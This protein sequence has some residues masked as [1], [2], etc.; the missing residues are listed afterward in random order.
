MSL[1]ITILAITVIVIVVGLVIL[2]IVAV[3][4]TGSNS[5]GGG[6]SQVPCSQVVDIDKL[7]QIPD[8]C[9]GCT[10]LQNCLDIGLYYIGGLAPFTYDY[11]VAPYPTTP[12][13][14]CVQF[15]QIGGYNPTTNTCVGP[16]FNNRTAQQNFDNCMTQ[17]S[18][19]DCKP[20][21]PIAA[22][23]PILY[24][25]ISPTNRSCSCNM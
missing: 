3:S 4:Q 12:V 20:P 7:I 18:S 6:N 21:V 8:V 10:C 13:N 15:C 1:G 25:A 11:V 14:V 16:E 23:G 9:S 2:I 5:G 24:Y 22:K 19:N 17:L